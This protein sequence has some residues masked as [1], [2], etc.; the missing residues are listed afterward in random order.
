MLIQALR[1]K[2]R[3]KFYENCQPLFCSEFIC[4]SSF[5]WDQVEALHWSLDELGFILDRTMHT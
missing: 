4:V 2:V 5:H 3:Q 1:Y